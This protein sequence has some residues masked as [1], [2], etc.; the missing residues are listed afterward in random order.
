MRETSSFGKKKGEE[1]NVFGAAKNPREEGKRRGGELASKQ[2]R[3]EGTVY[4]LGFL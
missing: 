4:L 2:G 3:R 1:E